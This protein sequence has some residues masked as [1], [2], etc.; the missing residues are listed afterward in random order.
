MESHTGFPSLDSTWL[1]AAYLIIFI[2]YLIITEKWAKAGLPE[3]RGPC[4]VDWCMPAEHE[5]GEL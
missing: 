1:F 4:G 5:K 2:F 3:V